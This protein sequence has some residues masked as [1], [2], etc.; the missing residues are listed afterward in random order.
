MFHNIYGKTFHIVPE[1]SDALIFL[2]DYLGFYLVNSFKNLQL[3]F[4]FWEFEKH[5]SGF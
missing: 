2:L 1:A 3:F 5:F 4:E